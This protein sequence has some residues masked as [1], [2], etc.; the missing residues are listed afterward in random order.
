MREVFADF[1]KVADRP[2]IG[3]SVYLGTDA[4]LAHIAPALVDGE[5]VLLKEPENLEANGVI[6]SREKQGIR[7]WFGII[8]G[9]IRDIHPETLAASSGEK[10]RS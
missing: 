10:Q 8:I 9:A 1:A 2:G 6:V 4:S 7:Q 3:Y 5:Q